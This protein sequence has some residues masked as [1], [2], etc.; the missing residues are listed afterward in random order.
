VALEEDE[1]DEEDDI[2]DLGIEEPKIDPES[3]NTPREP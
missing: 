1:E 2:G 3:W